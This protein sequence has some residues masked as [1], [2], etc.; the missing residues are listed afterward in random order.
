[1]SLVKCEVIGKDG[2]HVFTRP[3]LFSRI[4][5]IGE[6][7]RVGV[8]DYLV[9]RVIHTPLFEEADKSVAYVICSSPQDS[10]DQEA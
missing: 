5:L 7:V 10:E 2:R 1:M 9:V 4:P 6:S 3:T 8:L